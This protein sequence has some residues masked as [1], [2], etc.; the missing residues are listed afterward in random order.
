VAAYAADTIELKQTAR[1]MVIMM[2][3]INQSFFAGRQ[4]VTCWTCHQGE[5]VPHNVPNFQIQYNQ[6]LPYEPDDSPTQAPG[7]PSADE[8]L[9]K[10]LTAVGGAA[11][12]NAI[13]SIVGKG[14]NTGYG[15]ENSP[16]PLEIYA[17]T[18]PAIA[19]TTIT[20]TDD[21]DQTIT[22]DGVNGWE[23]V[24]HKPAPNPVLVMLGDDLAGKKLEATLM[25]PG[26]IK[27]AL[28]DWRVGFPFTMTVPTTYVVKAGDTLGAIARTN[29][30]TIDNIRALSG[31]SSNAITPGQRLTV[32]TDDKDMI[33]VQ[34]RT[35]P[36]GPLNKLIFDDETGLLMRLI[37]YTGSPIG[38]IPTQVDYRD[39]TLV[40]GV[41]IPLTWEVTWTDGR[42]TYRLDPKQVQ[43]NVAV[44]DSRF[45]KPPA[46][47]AKAQ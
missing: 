11:K 22:F 21:G 34:G 44:P 27:T 39:Y 8:V 40:N 25:F 38:K 28:T 45:V 18:T 6:V 35:R 15:P 7:Q 4:V 12:A 42:E 3:T 36:N 1:K 30:T 9:D 46:P 23:A 24:P 41:K 10:Y 47:V 14:T 13:T 29:G 32:K 37:R 26:K 31:L 17:R 5:Q 19:A 2:N 16:R 33:V 43:V 20:K